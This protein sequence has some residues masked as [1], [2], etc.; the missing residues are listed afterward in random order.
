MASLSIDAI[1]S[2]PPPPP[3]PEVKQIAPSVDV[4][5]PKKAGP[6]SRRANADSITFATV[7]GTVTQPNP[8]RGSPLNPAPSYNSKGQLNRTS[9]NGFGIDVKS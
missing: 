4:S 7:N 6:M 8:E 2:R 1:D 5:A 9:E 3:P